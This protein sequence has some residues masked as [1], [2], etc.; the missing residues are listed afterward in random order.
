M[1]MGSAEAEP[2][3][4]FAES[5]PLP[6]PL[7]SPSESPLPF[8]PLL[9][10]ESPL[11]PEP[12]LLPESPLPPELPPSEPLV[13]EPL[14]SLGVSLPLLPLPPD[15]LTETS[16]LLDPLVLE[17]LVPL[18][19][20]ASPPPPLNAFEPWASVV[21]LELESA[22][23]SLAS[24]PPEPPPCWLPVSSSRLPLWESCVSRPRSCASRSLRSRWSRTSRS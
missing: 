21:P 9:L 19:V 4:A 6:D 8:E 2:E 12:L 3:D 18:V 23:L 15:V 22:S 5:S 24:P 10:P 20:D 7:L 16:P 14:L 13:F 11:P 1:R 17:P